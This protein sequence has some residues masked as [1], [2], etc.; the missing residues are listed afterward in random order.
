MYKRVCSTNHVLSLRDPNP[1]PRVLWRPGTDKGTRS[2]A[3]RRT[4]IDDP[5]DTGTGTTPPRPLLIATLGPQIGGSAG[6]EAEE[7]NCIDRGHPSN[8]VKRG[9]R[10]IWYDPVFF[11]I[12]LVEM[13]SAHT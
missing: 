10:A 2:L 8:A 9:G 12:A 4:A 11:T 1:K 5:E 7:L 3:Q 13:C 6:G